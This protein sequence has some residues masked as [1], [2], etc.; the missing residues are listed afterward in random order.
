MSV[1]EW[2]QEGCRESLEYSC[3]ETEIKTFLKQKKNLTYQEFRAIYEV[4]FY[5]NDPEGKKCEILALLNQH[6]EYVKKF[7]EDVVLFLQNQKKAVSYDDFQVLYEKFY[8]L[9]SMSQ[10]EG[11]IL[12]ALEV[13]EG[14]TKRYWANVADKENVKSSIIEIAGLLSEEESG[15]RY[16][17]KNYFSSDVIWDDSDLCFEHMIDTLR[18][19]GFCGVHYCLDELPEFISMV[20]RLKLA[21]IRGLHIDAQ[22]FDE[23]A[24]MF[25]WFECLNEKWMF[26]GYELVGLTSDEEKYR[27]L[28]IK[29]ENLE[30]FFSLINKLNRHSENRWKVTKKKHDRYNAF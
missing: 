15:I 25:S 5:D 10:Q 30:S 28:I 21:Q 29:R 22:W 13:Y 18:N 11:E 7:L 20:S 24:S 16:E 14:Y 12:S 1:E 3:T 9:P 17:L 6:T 27:V 2:L 23:K 26:Q 8:F 19:Q 4:Y